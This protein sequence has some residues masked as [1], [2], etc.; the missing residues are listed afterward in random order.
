MDDERFFQKLC[1]RDPQAQNELIRT[2]NPRIFVYF[3]N[4]IKGEDHYEDLVQEV[5]SAFFNGLEQGKLAGAA[6]I[7]PFMFGIAKRVLYNYFYRQK[8]NNDIQKNISAVCELSTDFTESDRLE[9][10]RL[11][12]VLQRL[13]GDL[14]RVDR[15]ILNAYFLQ[16]KKIGEIAE[17]TGRSRHYISVRKDRAIKK[18][19]NEII[20]KNLY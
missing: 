9:N 2:F 19:R 14:P 7:A 4:R 11:G 10:L 17:M 18:I 16:E 20:R 13:I 12:E 3:R 1:A 5:F 15:T 6:W 8:K